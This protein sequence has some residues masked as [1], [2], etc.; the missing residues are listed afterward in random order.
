MNRLWDRIRRLPF[1]GGVSQP[2]SAVTTLER[3][4]EEDGECLSYELTR[5]PVK[6]INLRVL[7]DG[8]VRVS[9]PRSVP[10]EQIDDF[11]VSHLSFIER[12]RKEWR[13]RQADDRRFRPSYTEGEDIILLGR[14]VSLVVN[15]APSKRQSRMVYDGQSTLTLYALPEATYEERQ[16]MGEKF[17]KTWGHALFVRWSNQVQERFLAASYDV[18]LAQIKEQR[19]RSRW[20]SCMPSKGIIK[21]N[22]TLL[23]GPESFI[24]YVMVHEYAHFIHPN[25][26]PAF[27][28]VVESILPDWRMRKAQMRTY[29]HPSHHR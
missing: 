21:M 4:I 9:A 16:A 24:E 19:M 27:H 10:I 29:F 15:R 26:S 12:A 6:R 11:V 1:I 13:L 18:P 7:A 14:P 3:V 25:H 20:G 8:S 22:L 2:S 23:H 5:K 28:A 17:L